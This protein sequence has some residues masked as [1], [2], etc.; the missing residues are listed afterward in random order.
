MTLSGRTS[1]RD[2]H[3]LQDY[4]DGAVYPALFTRLPDAFPEFGFIDRGGNWVATAWP[5]TLTLEAADRRPDRLIAYHDRPHWLKLHGHEGVRWLDYVNGGDRPRGEAFKEAFRRLCDKAGVPCPCAPRTPEQM[6]QEQGRQDRRGILADLIELCRDFLRGE[7][8]LAA[9]AYLTKRGIGDETAREFGLGWCPDCAD[10]RLSELLVGKG[11]RPE[12]VEE[13]RAGWS[14]MRGYVTVPWNDELG[15]P[16]TVYGRWPGDPPLMRDHP[17][18]RGKRRD[19]AKAWAAQPAEGRASWQEPRLPKTF[20]L[21]GRESKC[22]P[23]YLDRVRKAG[24]T[25]VVVVEG[26]LD[27][28]ALQAAGETRAAASVAAQLSGS[29][30][31]TLTR[32]R[33]ERA[34][35]CGDPDGGGDRGTRRNVVHLAAAGVTPYVVPRLP[36]DQDPDEWV[37]EHGVDAWRLRVKQSAHGFRHLAEEDVAAHRALHGE[38]ADGDDLWADTLI[39]R[40]LATARKLPAERLDEVT[41]HLFG[42]VSAQTGALVEDLRKRL[43][44]TG[45]APDARGGAE[46]AGTAERFKFNPITVDELLAKTTAPSWV[47]KRLMVAQQPLL[48]AGGEKSFKT[49]LGIDLAVSVASG[50]PFLGVFDIYTRRRVV[51]LSGESG[52]HAIKDTIRR[53]CEARGISPAGLDLRLQFDLPQLSNALDVAELADGLKRLSASVAVLDPLYLMLLAGASGIDAANMF[54]MGPLLM[55]VS[56][57][58]LDAGCTPA[59]IHHANRPGAQKREPLCLTDLAYAGTSQFARQWLLLSCRE[60]FMPGEPVRLWLKGGG[61]CG[62]SGLWALDI[63]EGTLGEDFGGRKWDVTVNTVSEEREQRRE[64]AERKRREEQRGREQRDDGEFMGAVDRLDPGRKGLSLKAV[65]EAVRWGH[66]RTSEAADRLRA[67]GV[68][69]NVTGFT[70]EGGRGARTRAT[71]VRRAGG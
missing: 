27:A 5:A 59:M 58:C 29:Q 45:G 36:D 64:A 57:A 15:R 8:G 28:L 48:I 67:D 66:Q 50:A 26:V 61:S 63:D 37:N 6:A 55:A 51:L 9:R 12:Q 69:E 22:S 1:V 20:A 44:G 42:A 38:R 35:I 71:G 23:L 53:V 62:Q 32:C 40:A 10:C 31:E 16:L 49:S 54:Q 4:L 3:D 39:E 60:D 30:L 14:K 52:D 11:W 70:V 25:E 41:R 13:H 43:A 24:H 68:L 17:G 33:V 19:L 65:R 2:H 46:R 56:R 18:W 47:V 7:R 21:P 34:F